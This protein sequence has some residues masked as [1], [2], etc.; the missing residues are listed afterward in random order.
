LLKQLIGKDWFQ[1]YSKIPKLLK[2]YLVSFLS[3]TI[4]QILSWLLLQ[5]A[6]EM[7]MFKSSFCLIT[8][9]NLIT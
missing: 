3:I 9:L 5:K 2:T 6:A 4:L 8:K 1:R 7:S